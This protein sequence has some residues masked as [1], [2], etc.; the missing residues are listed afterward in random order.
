MRGQEVTEKIRSVTSNAA[1]QDHLSA[2]T[3]VL[4]LTGLSPCLTTPRPLAI[5]D[6][7]QNANDMLT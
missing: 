1:R 4:F 7:K 6:L 3:T 5:N 2:D